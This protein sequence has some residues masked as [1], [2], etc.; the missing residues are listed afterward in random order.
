LSALT[1]SRAARQGPNTAT[2]PLSALS[3]LRVEACI[4]FW[5]T[6]SHLQVV[7]AR[8]WRHLRL[9][10]CPECDTKTSKPPWLTRRVSAERRIVGTGALAFQ[11]SFLEI[12]YGAR[13]LGPSINR[14]G[15]RPECGADAAPRSTA[16][17]FLDGQTKGAPAFPGRKRLWH[18]HAACIGRRHEGRQCVRFYSLSASCCRAFVRPPPNPFLWSVLRR[19]GGRRIFSTYTPDKAGFPRG[20]TCVFDRRNLRGVGPFSRDSPAATATTT[21]SAC[22]WS[23]TITCTCGAINA[24]S[25]LRS[26][27]DEGGEGRGAAQR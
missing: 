14:A 3:E 20:T 27:S 22:S 1:I 21:P 2:A 24:V 16:Q 18:E 8:R 13:T 4:R 9:A 26:R 17:L 23:R 15:T 6:A 11:I 5:L 12:D 7:P 19:T 25:R 10:V